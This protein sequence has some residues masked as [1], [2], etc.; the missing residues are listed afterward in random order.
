MICAYVKYHLSSS[1]Q[2]INQT[3]ILKSSLPLYLS[4]SLSLPLNNKMV[5]IT[6]IN[7]AVIDCRLGSIYRNLAKNNID[8]TVFLLNDTIKIIQ[9]A[10]EYDCNER[11]VNYVVDELY[12][13]LINV[14]F[15]RYH[16]AHDKIR[17]LHYEIE[18]TF[19]I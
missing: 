6:L 16:M 15:G 1:K 12:R 14:A 13:S 3:N 7:P 5:S 9:G 8:N 10:T 2:T 18:K 11:F 17:D 19:M 4:I